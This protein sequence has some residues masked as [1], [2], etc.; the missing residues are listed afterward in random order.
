MLF[1]VI[2]I[3][4]GIFGWLIK[5][6]KVTWLISGFNTASEEK[7]AEYDIE[8]LCK[9]YGNFL[10]ILSTIYLLW[11]I[12]LLLLPLYTDLIIWCGFISSFVAIV[13]SIIY[14]N[15]GNRLKK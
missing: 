6:K 8:K 5:V 1:I 11:G 9:Y 12:I 10:Y 7:K 14:F 2:A 3:M 13:I 15:T 4:V